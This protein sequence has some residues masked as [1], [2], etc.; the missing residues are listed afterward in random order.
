M[1]SCVAALLTW[2]TQSISPIILKEQRTA[3]IGSAQCLT[4]EP[5]LMVKVQLCVFESDLTR[6]LC[7]VE[8]E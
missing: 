1:V 7:T 3:I 4:V 6:N 2:S 8:N 5:L